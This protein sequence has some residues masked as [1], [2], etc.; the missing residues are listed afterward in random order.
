MN[1]IYRLCQDCI[2]DVTDTKWDRKNLVTKVLLRFLVKCTVIMCASMQMRQNFLDLLEKTSFETTTTIIII[3]IIIKY[4][5]S[6][7]LQ[8][9]HTPIYIADLPTWRE[10]ERRDKN[11]WMVHWNV[12][13]S[14]LN[15]TWIWGI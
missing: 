3:I 14:H 2:N 10:G 15:K 11:D 13:I 12:S 8:G 7:I 6:F 4:R 1:R 9:C 5:F